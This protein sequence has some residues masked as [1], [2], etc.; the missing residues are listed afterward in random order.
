MRRALELAAFGRGW[1]EPN[2]MVGAVV[3]RD[4]QVVG[5]AFHRKYGGPHAEVLALDAA[6]DRARGATLYVTLEPCC[7]FGK[8]PP[9][10]ERVV[11][12][13]VRRVVAAMN[14]PFAEVAGRGAQMLREADLD[15]DIGCLEHDA[16][17]LNAPYLKLVGQRRPYVTAKWA[18]TLDGKIATS[19]GESK[20]ITGDVAREHALAFRGTVDA[21]IVGIGT[22]LADNPQLTARP[23]GPHVPT[24]VVVDSRGRLP[25]DCVLARTAREVPVLVATT[26]S[27]QPDAV[28]RLTG[29]GVECVVLPPNVDRRVSID[30]LLDACGKRRW[31]NVLVEGGSQLLGSFLD[32]GQID[33]VRVYVSPRVAG[34]GLA[35]G[36]VSGKGIPRLADLLSLESLNVTRLDRDLCLAG[37]VRKT[38]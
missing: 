35:K 9:C 20:W 12:S 34:G 10:T 8:T 33:A 38:H 14:D 7:H 18:M 31:T 26:P 17:T 13:G 2:P 32:S 11:R 5:E 4:G 25:S 19:A 27:I 21:V 15:V 30:A 24:R 3:V 36:P 29:M 37:A 6:G 28:D 16:Q 1:V 23:P 22:V